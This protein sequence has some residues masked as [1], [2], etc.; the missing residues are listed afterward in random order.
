MILLFVIV[1]ALIILA[2]SNDSAR[3]NKSQR[4]PCYW[5]ATATGEPRPNCR[6]NNRAADQ[7]G[8]KHARSASRKPG[9]DPPRPNGRKARQEAR[10]TPGP[11]ATDGDSTPESCRRTADGQNGKLYTAHARRNYPRIPR[12]GWTKNDKPEAPKPAKIHGSAPKNRRI[13]SRFSPFFVSILDFFSIFSRFSAVSIPSPS[14]FFSIQPADT[15]KIS[16]FFRPNSRFSPIPQRPGIPQLLQF[17]PIPKFCRF[18]SIS[19]APSVLPFSPF[20]AIIFSNKF[21]SFR[22]KF[23]KHPIW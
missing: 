13:P 11:A 8:K 19:R 22:H 15:P 6:Q 21:S 7:Q 16:R 9:Q 5:T 3:K 4:R 23:P 14:R 17:S 1:C 2:F 10:P 20:C 18:F 12:P